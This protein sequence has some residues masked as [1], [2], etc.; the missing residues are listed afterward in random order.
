M[1][2]V[3][4][5]K[6]AVIGC[7]Y[8]GATCAFALMQAGTFSEIVLIDS[9]NDRAEGEALDISAGV[10]FGDSGNI[11]AGSYDDIAD[12]SVV[13][14][15][16]G[17]NQKPGESRLDL[18]KRN[19]AILESITPNIAKSGFSGVV[20]MVANPVDIL[21]CATARMLE[22]PR[23]RVLGT[24]TVLDTA[25]LKY[26]VGQYLGVDSRSVHAFIIGEHGD[27]EVPVW[28]SANVSGVPL[29]DFARLRGQEDYDAITAKLARQVR[30]SAQAII[31]KKGATYYGIAMSVNRVCQCIVRDERSILPVSGPMDGAYGLEGVALSMPAIV[32]A[33]GLEC[34]VN[35]SLDQSEIDKLNASVVTLR[36]V[37]ESLG[38]HC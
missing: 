6:A 38:L 33:N 4:L 30:D 36:G 14:I 35:I 31:T 32:G 25:R 22:L 23:G 27:S 2:S 1:G 26:A 24:G 17:A 28:S 18:V 19:L 34:H 29:A 10:P 12:A 11:Y 13:V 9:N 3:D 7:G 16:A 37:L 8:V 21:T 5:R 20:L 15:T